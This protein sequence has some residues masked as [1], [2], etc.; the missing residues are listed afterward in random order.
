MRSLNKYREQVDEGIGANL[1]RKEITQ[2]NRRCSALTI[3]ELVE[4]KGNDQ[5]AQVGCW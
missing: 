1:N 4:I 3:V 2:R 5:R